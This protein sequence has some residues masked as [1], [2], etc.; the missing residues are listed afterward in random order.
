MF[1]LQPPRHTSTLPIPAVR[2][3]LPA[4]Q[5]PV[6]DTHASP[7]SSGPRC[8]GNPL[9]ERLTVIRQHDLDPPPA[10]RPDARGHAV[11]RIGYGRASFAGKVGLN[12]AAVARRATDRIKAI[13][14]ANAAFWAKRG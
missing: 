1:D 2:A 11:G 10:S 14:A 7:P 6:C 8:S 9:G 13:N 12:A 3:V 4:L 5:R